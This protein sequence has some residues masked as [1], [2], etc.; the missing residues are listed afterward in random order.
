MGGIM[1]R[2]WVAAAALSLTLTGGCAVVV[3]LDATDS[4]AGGG[5]VDF[6]V[7]TT[8]ESNC[9][10]GGIGKHKGVFSVIVP[11]VP[12][13]FVL[14]L[15]GHI[16]DPVERR[17]ATEAIDAFCA[18]EEILEAPIGVSGACV[19]EE[20]DIV[21][22]FDAGTPLPLLAGDD[23]VP[24]T[25]NSGFDCQTGADGISCRISESILDGVPLEANE[26][27]GDF[28][29]CFPLGPII[30]CY[31]PGLA[32]GEM[33]MANFDLE[34]DVDDG[35]YQ[36]WVLT[37]A[38]PSGG[39]CFSS[40]LPGRPCSDDDDCTTGDCGEG[41]CEGGSNA[42]YGCDD[43]GDCTDGTCVICLERTGPESLLNGIDC[44]DTQVGAEV[45][46]PAMSPGGILL[47]IA[48]LFG[49]GMVMSRR[50]RRGSAV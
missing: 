25:G 43:S 30:V 10:V 33:Q 6:K 13:D 45:M 14:Y 23:A 7:K 41:I 4:V 42:G 40:T 34:A 44:A 2:S 26:A 36:H 46:A 32:A 18:G 27:N 16:D 28:P 19:F 5:T 9:P 24:G 1:K 49:A 35:L 12:R 20:N 39:I 11:F 3:E 48:G 15:L 29:K 47:V 21:C 22:N 50:A 17:E 37:V 31:S 8:N 38:K